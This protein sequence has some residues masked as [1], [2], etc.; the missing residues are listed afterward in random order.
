MAFCLLYLLVR[1]FGPLDKHLGWG[2]G[3]SYLPG[4]RWTFPVWPL[5]S[6]QT[7]HGFQPDRIIDIVIK[8][9]LKHIILNTSIVVGRV[10]I[11]MTFFTLRGFAS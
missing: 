1:Q 7:L 5:S 3:V 2:G 6:L 9:T 4:H 10:F 11:K 8:G